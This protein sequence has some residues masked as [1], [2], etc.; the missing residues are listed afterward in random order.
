[1]PCKDETW[2]LA[3]LEEAR[4]A[5]VRGDLPVGAVVVAGDRVLACAGNEACTSG[6]PTAHAEVVAL[7]RL[8]TT[9]RTLEDGELSLYTTFEPCPMCLGA[10]LVLGVNR[11]VIGGRRPPGDTTWGAYTPELLVQLTTPP[12][13]TVVE[14]GPFSQECT[15]LRSE[16][17][18]S[19][20]FALANRQ[21]S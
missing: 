21:G 16:G 4:S 2:M 6:D 19:A 3:A 10:A 5:G 17:T 20:A 18:G 15:A 8:G 7:R 9:A 14:Y 1:M 12:L 13:P 11:I